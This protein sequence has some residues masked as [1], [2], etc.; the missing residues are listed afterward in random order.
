MLDTMRARAAAALVLAALAGCSGGDAGRDD[1]LALSADSTRV[2]AGTVTGDSAADSVVGFGNATTL[3]AAHILELLAVANRGEIEYSRAALEKL[4]SAEL[5]EYARAMIADHEAMLKEG[6][7]LRQALRVAPQPSDR[8]RNLQEEQMKDVGDLR[9]ESGD[10]ANRE[11]IEEQVDMHQ[12]T[13]DLLE[14]LDDDT[15]DPRLKAAVDKARPKVRQHLDR[16]KQLQERLG[17]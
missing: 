16:A 10:D 9:G 13:L 7:S 17:A 8:S 6:D 11:F 4:T 14:D 15:N 3:S 12:E 5:K 2:S 1:T